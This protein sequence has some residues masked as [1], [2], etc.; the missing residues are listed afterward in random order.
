MADIRSNCTIGLPCR[1]TESNFLPVVKMLRDNPS[2]VSENSY[3][4]RV[5]EGGFD[6]MTK[7]V[8]DVPGGS[9][10]IGYAT[11]PHKSIAT[12][13]TDTTI[14]GYSTFYFDSDQDLV[15]LSFFQGSGFFSKN[16]DIAPVDKFWLNIF[17]LCNYSVGL[18]EVFYQID[19]RDGNNR[20]FDDLYKVVGVSRRGE[21]CEK[22]ITAGFAAPDPQHPN[23]GFVLTQRFIDLERLEDLDVPCEDDKRAIVET[24]NRFHRNIIPFEIVYDLAKPGSRA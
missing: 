1:V 17:G 12:G 3:I 13:P 24:I 5:P 18:R 21:L 10:D 16:T 8:F 6:R 2:L 11:R 23:F 19:Q 9:L 7:F 20:L 15:R 22:L 4:K 14:G